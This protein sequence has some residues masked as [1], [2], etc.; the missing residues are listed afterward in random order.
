MGRILKVLE[1]CLD[2]ETEWQVL[3]RVLT[4]LPYALQYEMNLVKGSSFINRLIKHFHKR[5]LKELRNKP[6]SVNKLEY[7]SKYYPLL[8]SLV[9]FHPTL[10]RSSHD[11]ILQSFLPA[12]SNRYCLEILTIAIVEMH[13]TNSMQCGEILLRFNTFLIDI[14]RAYIL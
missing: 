6:E 10:D 8:A 11:L 1:S 13:E 9:L 3:M 14:C 4:D 2:K 5:D 12:F 7:M